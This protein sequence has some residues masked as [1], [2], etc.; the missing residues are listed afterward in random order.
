MPGML[1]PAGGASAPQLHTSPLEL[2]HGIHNAAP[3]APL[4]PPQP[5]LLRSLLPATAAAMLSSCPCPS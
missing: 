2:T 4:L 3:A 5:L 1:P